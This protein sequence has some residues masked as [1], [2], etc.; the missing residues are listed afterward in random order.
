MTKRE[1]SKSSC[2][3]ICSNISPPVFHS[4]QLSSAQLTPPPA[5]SSSRTLLASARISPI[6]YITNFL[7]QLPSAAAG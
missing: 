6:S 5:S 2:S 1:T 4:S 7:M 3:T